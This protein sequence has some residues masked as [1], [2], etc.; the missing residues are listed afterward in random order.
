MSDLYVQTKILQRQCHTCICGGLWG[1]IP[2]NIRAIFGQKIVQ[3]G[4]DKKKKEKKE[5]KN[6]GKKERKK[7]IT[8]VCMSWDGRGG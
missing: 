6:K 2:P 4:E 1:C 8:W 5:K 7:N 3:I